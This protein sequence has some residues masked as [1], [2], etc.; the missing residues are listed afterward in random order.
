MIGN[1]AEI[2]HTHFHPS[3]IRP[4]PAPIIHSSTASNVYWQ[5]TKAKAIITLHMMPMVYRVHVTAH[6][7]EEHK[8][9]WKEIYVYLI[10]R[11]H[12]R[13]TQPCRCHPC[14]C[15]HT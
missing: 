6:M 12:I 1:Y 2:C 15:Q 3:G 10:P 5:M 8:K 4:P 13:S 9:V 14:Q 11:S 7:Y